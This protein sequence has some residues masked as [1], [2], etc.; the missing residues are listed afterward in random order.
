MWGGGQLVSGD[1][2]CSYPMGCGALSAG[3][4]WGASRAEAEDDAPRSPVATDAMGRSSA[5]SLNAAQQVL[6]SAFWKPL[7]LTERQ[8]ARRM[9]PP[10]PAPARRLVKSKAGCKMCIFGRGLPSG[11]WTTCGASIAVGAARSLPAWLDLRLRASATKTWVG[12]NASQLLTGENLR[13]SV[14]TLGAQA[15]QNLGQGEEIGRNQRKLAEIARNAV[16][17]ARKSVEID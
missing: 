1:T 16:Q 14:R 10:A 3:S 4:G 12:Q 8:S 7:P 13:S 2:N 5:P 15:F 9:L 6:P 11:V 17:P